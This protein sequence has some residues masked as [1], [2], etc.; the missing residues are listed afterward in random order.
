MYGLAGGKSARLL[1]RRVSC[2]SFT[3]PATACIRSALGIGGEV[4]TLLRVGRYWMPVCATTICEA[5]LCHA[6]MP[7]HAT[8][9]C[10]VGMH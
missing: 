1:V 5:E 8:E 9:L 10:L 4:G 6:M 7:R 2:C 3:F